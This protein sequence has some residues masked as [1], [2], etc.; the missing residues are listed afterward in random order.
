MAITRKNNV[1]SAEGRK[2]L[3][4]DLFFFLSVSVCALLF[5]AGGVFGALNGLHKTYVQSQATLVVLANVFGFLG[6]SLVFLLRQG[7]GICISLPVVFCWA[8]F[9]M[10]HLLGEMVLFYYDVSF[11]DKMLHAISGVL[12]FFTVFGLIR[13]YCAGKGINV[14]LAADVI[15]SFAASLAVACLWEMIEF[16]MDG[17]FGTNMQKF[18]PETEALF[19][20]G[21]SF[22]ALKGTAEEI[23]EFY[24]QPQ[25]YRYALTDTMMDCVVCLA[26]TI[27]AIIPAVALGKKKPDFMTRTIYFNGK[28]KARKGKEEL[29]EK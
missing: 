17:V 1:G 27:A 20:G 25:G 14:G 7:F 21:N 13:T 10:L 26:G 18:I 16:T 12:V 15:I 29:S 3:K 5:A 6:V 28:R 4:S 9:L 2:N 23:A 19:N 11:W 22:E 8:A 24:R